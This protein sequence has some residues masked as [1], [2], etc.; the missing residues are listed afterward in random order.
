MLS[1]QVTLIGIVPFRALDD[2]IIGQACI[3]ARTRSVRRGPRGW[4]W[5]AVGTTSIVIPHCQVHVLH[6]VVEGIDRVHEVHQDGR[7]LSALLD[8][9]RE[10]SLLKDATTGWGGGEARRD[11]RSDWVDG[12][13]RVVID[14]NDL[15]MVLS[16]TIW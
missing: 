1:F 15:P 12:R 5:S 14:I 6:L 16:V 8:M 4:W 9:R 10:R 13:Q 7:G 3:V 2:S 11:A